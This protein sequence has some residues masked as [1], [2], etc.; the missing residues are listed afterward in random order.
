MTVRLRLAL[1]VFLTGLA[2]AVAEM[3]SICQAYPL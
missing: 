2:T 3:K 1:T